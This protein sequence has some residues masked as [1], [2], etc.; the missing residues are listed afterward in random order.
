MHVIRES[1]AG[2][3][4]VTVI[5]QETS[6]HLHCVF[7]WMNGKYTARSPLEYF[8][9]ILAPL[10][11]CI[12]VYSFYFSSLIARIT[13]R[14]LLKQASPLSSWLVIVCFDRCAQVSLSA[15]G[16]SLEPEK[17]E[18]LYLA[19]TVNWMMK[20]TYEYLQRDAMPG[21]TDSL[22]SS[23]EL[24]CFRRRGKSLLRMQRS[25]RKVLFSSKYS[26]VRLT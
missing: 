15:H 26:F 23:S 1:F 21:L 10:Y 13:P 2:I 25:E 7:R 9:S 24:K 18:V 6:H 8:F 16:A 11:F 22:F 19:R 3:C 5:W 12:H 4:I 20:R 14:P 17:P